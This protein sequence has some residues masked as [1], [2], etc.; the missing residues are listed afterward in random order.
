MRVVIEIENGYR[1][2]DGQETQHVSKDNPTDSIVFSDGCLKE[3][4]EGIPNRTTMNRYG[5]LC[6]V[7]GM[8]SDASRRT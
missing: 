5:T 7:N 1:K 4:D 6:R 3:G 8:I 2:I